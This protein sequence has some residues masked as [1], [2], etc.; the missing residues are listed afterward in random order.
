MHLQNNHIRS[1]NKR[2]FAL[3]L[4]IIDTGHFNSKK[5]VFYLESSYHISQDLLRMIFT[6]T[7]LEHIGDVN[8]IN[9][10]LKYTSQMN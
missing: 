4:E 2:M 1:Y 10:M 8:I 7:Q 6:H 5:K 9:N 3:E